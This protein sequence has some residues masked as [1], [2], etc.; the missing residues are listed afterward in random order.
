MCIRDRLQDVLQNLP[1]DSLQLRGDQEEDEVTPTFE[2]PFS[3]KATE[4]AARMKVSGV[5]IAKTVATPDVAPPPPAP[6]AKTS[7]R[8]VPAPAGPTGEVEVTQ[9]AKTPT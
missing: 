2:T 6:V 1:S 4:D 5:P 7:P 3:M 8:P 9:P